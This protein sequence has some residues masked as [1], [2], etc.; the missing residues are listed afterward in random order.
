MTQL[1]ALS[2]DCE[3]A[4]SIRLKAI[5]AVGQSLDSTYGWGF[6]WYPSAEQAAMVIKDPRA[7]SENALSSVLSKWDRF[8]STSFV[9]HLRGAAKRRSQKDTHPFCRPW[10]GRDWLFTHNGDLKHRFREALPLPPNPVFEPLG[11]TDSEYAF[12]WLLEQVRSVG[13]R[14]IRDVESGLF[15]SW[16]RQINGQGTANLL[17]ADG[18]DMVAYSDAFGYRP[19]WWARRTPPDSTIRFENEEVAMRLGSKIGESRTVVVISTSPLSES[20]WSLIGDGALLRISRGGVMEHLTS[21][22]FEEA[23]QLQQTPAVTP[24]QQQSSASGAPAL[25]APG[26]ISTPTP[27]EPGDARRE[28]TDSSN[29]VHRELTNSEPVHSDGA[30]KRASSMLRAPEVMDAGL[31]RE[32]DETS[33]MSSA[34]RRIMETVHETTFQYDQP[35]ESSW[36]MFRFR[37]IHDQMQEVVDYQLEITPQCP[38]RTFEDVFGNHTVEMKISNPYEELKIVSRATIIMHS[39]RTTKLRSAMQSQ[40]LPLVWMPWQRQ[41]MLPYLLPPEL[42]ETQLRELSDYAMSFVERQDHDLVD[43]LKDINRTIFRDYEYATGSTTLQTTPFDVYSTRKGVCQD[44]ANLFIA[45]ARLLS[46]PARYSVGYIFT[47]SKYQNARQGDESHAWVEVY[48][49]YIGWRGF[50]PTNGVQVGDDHVR[51]AHG[52]N[53]SDASPT[54]GTIYSGGGIEKMT[55][56]VEVRD[57]T[58]DQSS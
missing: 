24:P 12:C 49:P 25:Q 26:S 21:Q 57:V 58:E 19:L 29:T 35:V 56:R 44:F 53:Y 10:G 33:E 3:T 14:R 46:I 1:I 50:D 23:P 30:L 32:A 31:A 40:R 2:F 51:V 45:M 55:V 8:S 16:L 13:A 38:H 6:A 39:D 18:L 54:T 27:S 28:G 22:P 17:I 34:G 7:V 52:R 37:P 4:P 41:M 48:L 11:N 43:T 15:H 42:P 5:N 20:G 36:H 9:A 47:G